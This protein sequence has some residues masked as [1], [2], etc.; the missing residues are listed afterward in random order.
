[1]S[2][3][4]ILFTLLAVIAARMAMG[5]C[6]FNGVALGQTTTSTAVVQDT[7][8]DNKQGALW[9]VFGRSDLA[10]VS[11]TNKRLE[12]I[13][14][15]DANETFVGYISNKWWI[16]PSEDFR[17]KLD[18]YF[19][20]SASTSGW[21]ALGLTPN[22]SGPGDRYVMAGIGRSRSFENY[23]WELKNKSYPDMDFVWRTRKAVTFYIS[24]DSWN[25]ILYIGDTGYGEENAWRILPDFAAT[26]WGSVPYYVFLGI[27][28]DN[29]AVSSGAVYVDNFVIEKGKIG[30]SYQG[31]TGDSSDDSPVI[32]DVDA[33]L[34]IVPSTIY[35]K[36]TGTKVTMVVSL[37]A[38]ITL[39][40]WD[41]ADVPVLTPGNL[42]ATAQAAFC[43]VDGTV[44]VL[45]S[46]SRSELLEAVTADG[47]TELH[48]AGT[49]KD[50][51]TYAGSCTVTIE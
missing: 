14:S 21:V 35:R 38:G 26:C 27:T 30:S 11:E 37:P 2:R 43:W 40:D 39:A 5:P 31:D 4:V 49:L 15:S 22:S 28:T 42:A 16:D 34:A 19:S 10:K 7:F 36:S 50:E 41:S 8:D 51:R 46:F 17:M 33:T 20:V 29:L 13:T 47:E 1:M 32:V 48:F 25:D 6:G 9:T 24:Y 44:K 23:W 45:V 3:T 18:M 12:F